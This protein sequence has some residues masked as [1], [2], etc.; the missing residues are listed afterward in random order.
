MINGAYE[1]A[2]M[3]CPSASTV[4][5]F[6]W[7]YSVPVGRLTFAPWM[8]V[9]TSSMPNPCAESF[10]GST[11]MRTAYFCAPNTCTCATPLTMEMRCATVESAYSL[12]VVSG[13][14]SERSDSRMTGK[15]PGLTF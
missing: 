2:R 13:S 15:S 7:P 12:T 10:R 3:S 5:I 8:A 1:D 6:C 9:T 11:S 4:N 14:V